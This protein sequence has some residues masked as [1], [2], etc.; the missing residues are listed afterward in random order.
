MFQSDQVALENCP[1][2]YFEEHSVNVGGTGNIVDVV[3]QSGTP[4]VDGSSQNQWN[5][6]V[7]QKNEEG[8]TSWADYW[9]VLLV[10]IA[11]ILLGAYFFDDDEPYQSTMQYNASNAYMQQHPQSPYLMQPPPQVSQQS[12]HLMQPPQVSQVPYSIT[13]PI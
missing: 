4:A 6:N 10:L 12:P 1:P 8:V 9:W 5:T 3:Q 7:N 2:I 11:A 13:A